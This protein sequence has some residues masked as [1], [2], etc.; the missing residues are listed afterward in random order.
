VNNNHK[1]V[2]QESALVCAGTYTTLT[3][4]LSLAFVSVLSGTT[5][6]REIE[7]MGL[8]TGRFIRQQ[9][10]LITK[11][12][13]KITRQKMTSIYCMSILTTEFL[14]HLI[15]VGKSKHVHADIYVKIYG[16]MY[17]RMSYRHLF[18]RNCV[19]VK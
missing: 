8:N 2:D 7:P 16:C 9:L 5:R 18:Y 13:I 3:V 6:H 1:L 17:V 4:S 11:Q 15:M 19:N 14:Q 12:T 10:M